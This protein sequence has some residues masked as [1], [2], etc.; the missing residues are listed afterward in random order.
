[1]EIPQGIRLGDGPAD[2]RP[3]GLAFAQ[4][5]VGRLLRL[6]LGVHLTL[7]VDRL[8]DDQAEDDQDGEA[9]HGED[10]GHHLFDR[11]LFLLLDGLACVGILQFLF[12]VGDQVRVD[13]VAGGE[14]PPVDVAEQEFQVLGEF[15]VVDD[16]REDE[17]AA[18]VADGECQLFLREL[19]SIGIAAGQV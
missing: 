15:A 7:L 6:L 2:L 13:V 12:D 17:M 18:L 3:P 11:T 9:D 4:G 16:Q 14:D 5:G 1:M 10:D 8:P 19:G